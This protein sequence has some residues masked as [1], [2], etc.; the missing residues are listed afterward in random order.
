[1]LE[2]YNKE[3]LWKIYQKLPEELKDAL[4]SEDTTDNIYNICERNEIEEVPEVTKIVALILLGVLPLESL[5]ETLRGELKLKTERARK[6]SQEINRFIFY[7]VK[8]GLD[9]LYGLGSPGPAPKVDLG[10]V[11]I[12]EEK[13]G[14]TKKPASPRKDTYRESLDIK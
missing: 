5:Q 2:E 10:T 7:P 6:V 9:S 8:R 11:P 12:P 3:K 14:E 1:M 13:P 4:F